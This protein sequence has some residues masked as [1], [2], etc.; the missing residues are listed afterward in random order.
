MIIPATNHAPIGLFPPGA[1]SYSA[2][3]N[4]YLGLRVSSNYQQY[5]TIQHDSQSRKLVGH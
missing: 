3:S 1:N 4:T 5:S 2:I